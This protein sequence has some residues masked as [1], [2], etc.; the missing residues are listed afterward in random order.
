MSDAVVVQM[1]N[2]MPVPASNPDPL[3]AIIERASRDPSVD[4]DKMQRLLDMRMRM[5]AEDARAQYVTAFAAMQPEMP[6]IARNGEIKTNEKNAKGEKTGNQVKQSKYALWEDIDAAIRPILVRHG[7]ALSFRVNQTAERLAVK[8]VLSHKAGHSEETEVSLPIDTSGSKNN[9]QGWGSSLSYGKRYSTL[10][11]L[12]VVTHGEDDD[13]KKAGAAETISEEQE[14]QLRELIEAT[15]TNLAIFCRYYKILK[16]SDLSV[17]NFTH[18]V[19][20]LNG[21]LKK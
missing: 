12:N 11:L 8:A 1:P 7:F 17:A 5:Q 10:A 9:V 15:E 2:S 14:A 4:I 6:T 21:K 19:A 3:L 16:I 20:A 13:G 18:A